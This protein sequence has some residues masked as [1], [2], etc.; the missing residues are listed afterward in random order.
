MT[1]ALNTAST[2]RVTSFPD[3]L[4]RTSVAQIFSPRYPTI[5]IDELIRS[6]KV[7]RIGRM[8]R[9]RVWSSGQARH[10]G[11]ACNRTRIGRCPKWRSAAAAESLR[12][13]VHRSASDASLPVAPCQSI[14]NHRIGIR[15]CGSP[16]APGHCVTAQPARSGS[17]ASA[18]AMASCLAMTSFSRMLPSLAPLTLAAAS[19]A[20][21]RAAVTTAASMPWRAL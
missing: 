2:P 18:R 12:G 15:L 5:S 6:C 8:D 19:A 14:P 16:P 4:R 10:D 7:E 1:R 17:G 21:G 11:N 9:A 13:D 20:F 3:S